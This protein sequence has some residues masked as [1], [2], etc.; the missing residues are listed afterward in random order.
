MATLLLIVPV[1]IVFLHGLLKLFP[2]IAGP[3]FLVVVIPLIFVVYSIAFVVPQVY[4]TRGLRSLLADAP[5]TTERITL[6]DQ[7]AKAATS[8][9]G[10]LLAVL[11][12]SGLIMMAAGL[13]L[14]L[15]TVVLESDGSLIPAALTVLIG[16]AMLTAYIVYLM[17]LKA[18]LKRA[19]G[20]EASAAFPV[21]PR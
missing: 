2:G 16:G 7:L 12:V 17:R 20:A 19:A 1:T 5:R 8:L 11:L 21:Q 9:S 18:K 10:K 3:G 4:L 15:G 13:L 14:L 6:R